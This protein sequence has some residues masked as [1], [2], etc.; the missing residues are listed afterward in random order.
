MYLV[1]VSER[2]V[3]K[4]KRSAGKE[5]PSYIMDAREMAEF[6]DGEKERS[7]P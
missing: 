7:A 5:K 1:G 3:M 6:Q 4:Q 2:E